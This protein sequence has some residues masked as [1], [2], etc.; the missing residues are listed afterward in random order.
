MCTLKTPVHTP[1]ACSRSCLAPAVPSVGRGLEPP[2]REPRGRPGDP[3]RRDGTGRG[4]PGALEAP[5]LA[6]QGIVPPPYPCRGGGLIPV[7][8]RP[9]H[10]PTGRAG[11]PANGGGTPGP[12]PAAG[13]QSGRAAPH[14]S[15]SRPVPSRS[16]SR[17]R[18]H[19]CRWRRGARVRGCCWRRCCARRR[20]PGARRAVPVRSGGCWRRRPSGS[21]WRSCGSG[22][23]RGSP[24]RC[25]EPPLPAPC[26]ACKRPVLAGAPTPR[27]GATRSSAS[28]SQV[29]ARALRGTVAI[30][31]GFSPATEEQASRLGCARWRPAG[32]PRVGATPP[33]GTESPA[34]GLV[35]VRG[36]PGRV[37]SLRPSGGCGA[38]AGHP[39]AARWGS[40]SRWERDCS[41]GHL[42][43]AGG[44]P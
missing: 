41:F 22:N 15:W 18:S 2:P 34:L 30:P 16:R 4:R 28:P 21:S 17:S 26:G 27:S 5:S 36:S 13:A 43:C 9:S 8:P 24:T 38:A 29:G 19:R 40:Q 25:P 14:H 23:G 31:G 32:G 44:L 11:E 12:P 37:R 33:R 10:S 20:S 7:I 42:L 3:S 6:P 35:P 1:P 39:L